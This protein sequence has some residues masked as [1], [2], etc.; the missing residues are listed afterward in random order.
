M[1]DFYVILVY[2]T[3]VHAIRGFFLNSLSLSLSP[4]LS[5]SNLCF[6]ISFS[7]TFSLVSSLVIKCE[8][9]I[10]MPIFPKKPKTKQKSSHLLSRWMHSFAQAP[11]THTLTCTRT[12]YSTLYLF[13]PPS[14]N[15]K[16][17]SRQ[18]NKLTK[19]QIFCVKC[20]QIKIEDVR[21]INRGNIKRS[22][23]ERIVQL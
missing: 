17:K 22:I 19:D 21:K 11:H 23:R 5:I 14:M 13:L 8:C 1:G 16:R 10:W 15:S 18:K 20:N 12:P 3:L 9:R 4:S 2:T 6:V 7:L